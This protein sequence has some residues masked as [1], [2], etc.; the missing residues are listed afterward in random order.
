MSIFNVIN[1]PNGISED[2]KPLINRYDEDHISDSDEEWMLA[3]LEEE[4]NDPTKSRKPKIVQEKEIKNE[5]YSPKVHKKPTIQVNRETIDQ[6]LVNQQNEGIK[7]KIIKWIPWGKKDEPPPPPPQPQTISDRVKSVVINASKTLG[8]VKEPERPKKWYEIWAEKINEKITLSKRTRLIGFGITFALGILCLILSVVL[9][10]NIYL[11]YFPQF[12]AL[13]YSLSQVFFMISSFFL[14]GPMKQ[15]RQMLTPKRVIPS[16]IY[17]LSLV[18]TLI[19]AI[20][21]KNFIICFI[22]I[23][24]QIIALVIYLITYI[25]YSDTIFTFALRSAW[26]SVTA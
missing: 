17:L 18:L 5:L 8:I 22:L 16:C 9:L 1:K 10:S 19:S 4:I 14:A 13:L 7:D 21:M 26:N 20:T 24:I 23:I 2:Y 25:P 3:M 15:I 12:F 11:P 6:N